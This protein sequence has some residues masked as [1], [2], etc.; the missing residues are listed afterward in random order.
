MYEKIPKVMYDIDFELNV[1]KKVVEVNSDSLT[2]SGYEECASI[3]ADEA[4]KIGL[5]VEVFDSKLK[6]LD[7]LP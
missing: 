3:V 6:S 7:K 2:K 5:K 4:E 1:L